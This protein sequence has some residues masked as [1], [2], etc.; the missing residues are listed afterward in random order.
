MRLILLILLV[1]LL[2]GYG[3]VIAQEGDSAP[4]LTPPTLVPTP[5]SNVTDALLTESAVARIQRD[6]LVRVGVLYNAPPFAE[7]SLSGEVIGFD[8]D[9]AR[10]MAETWGVDYQLLQVTRQN[11]HHM[12]QSG[13]VDFLLAAQVHRREWD[14]VIE[15]S[16]TYYI[17]A[18]V[19][20]TRADDPAE[21]LAN[22][23]GRRIGYVP[24]TAGEKALSEWE[25][26]AGIQLAKQPYLTLDRAYVALVAGEV[27]GVVASQERLR[28]LVT[29]PDL[30]KYLAEPL[31]PEPYAIAFNRQDVPLRNLI[32]R[33]LQYLARTEA[34]DT[35]YVTYFPA[36][37][38][39]AETVIQWGD[40]GDSAPQP[41]DFSPEISYP[42]Q[43]ILP[44][45]LS[46]GSIRVAGVSDLAP[47]ASES[48]RRVHN[49][50]RQVLEAFR[51]RWGVSVEF[52]SDG[53]NPLE[54]VARGSA[55]MALGVAPSWEWANRVDFSMPYLQHGDRLM[56]PVNRDIRGF[57]ELRNRWVAIMLTDDDAE[58]R[59]LAWAESINARINIY[60]TRE[61][62]V[63]FAILEER[64]ADVAYG[65]S[66]KLIPILDANPNAFV[67]TKAEDG[68][69]RWY[70]RAYMAVAVPRNDVDFRLLVDYTLQE[71]SADGTLSAILRLVSLP[72]E[73]FRLDYWP[74]PNAFYGLDL[75]GR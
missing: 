43:Y 66:L 9:L 33:T 4:T 59:A 30:I 73:P 40:V 12:L 16:Q 57:N 20:M 31:A 26:K 65:D 47:D 46:G 62:D 14:S 6:G 53:G 61:E 2:L 10:L 25:T 35:L 34:L 11:A 41:S 13:V 15:F 64:N 75:T 51:A 17:G 48:A 70:S 72:D 58:E 3:F 50:N 54:M 36:S 49:V 71:M 24:V 21:A 67:L 18:Q 23:V 45:V 63:A 55:D 69:P 32:N 1:F 74:G 39:A 28:I 68:Q 37:P 44:R 22:M 29:Q 19:M 60:K 7:L 27:D 42:T 38:N 5:L 52:V 8:A 56:V